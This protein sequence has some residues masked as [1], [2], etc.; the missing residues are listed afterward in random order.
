MTPGGQKISKIIRQIAYIKLPKVQKEREIALKMK[1]GGVYS[2]AFI[3]HKYLPNFQACPALVFCT[4]NN[5]MAMDKQHY[6]D[7]R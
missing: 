6:I 2:Q 1:T 7:I 5:I 3:V 4:L